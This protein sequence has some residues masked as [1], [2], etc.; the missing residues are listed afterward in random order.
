MSFDPSYADD[1]L[2]PPPESSPVRQ[3][4]QGP[5]IGLIVAGVLNLFVALYLVVNTIYL[6]VTPADAMLA[7]QKAVYEKMFPAMKAELAK[8][9]PAELKTQAL[10]VNGPLTVLGFL[11]S[12]L[13][14]V[15]GIRMLGLKSYSL[16]ICGAICAMIPCVSITAC[17][18]VGE[19]IGIWALVILMNEEVRS[20][21]R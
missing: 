21:F 13:P 18:G 14:V 4:V 9:T 12:F 8:K 11:A 3:R 10:L 2:P 20:A 17:C 7:Q 6:L 16:A 19:A 15:G 1:D 5:A